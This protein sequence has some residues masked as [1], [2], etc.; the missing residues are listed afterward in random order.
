M[1]RTFDLAF[2]GG[3]IK[4]VAFVGALEAFDA[5]GHASRRLVGTSAGAIFAAA[6]AVGYTPAE[7]RRAILT[8]T[9]GR[10]PFADF[11]RV[12]A[13]PSG[14]AGGLWAAAGVTVDTLLGRV[15]PKAVGWGGRGLTFLTR[16]AVF[17]PTPFRT[18]MSQILLDKGVSPDEPLAELHERINRGRPQQLTL[19]AADVTAQEVL[20][21][22]ERTAPGL[23]ILEAVRMSMSIP[24]V[25]PEVE[26]RAEWGRYRGTDRAG[27]RVVDGGLLSNFPIRYLLDARYTAADGVLGPLAGDARP[28]GLFLD[29]DLPIP[30]L[31][32]PDREASILQQVPA[33]QSVLRVVDAMTDA[34]DREALRDLIPP[35]RERAIC[36]I[37]TKGV[38]PLDFGAD[39]ATLAG[40]IRSGR[41]AM[42]EW[43]AAHGGTTEL[44]DGMGR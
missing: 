19:I 33:V 4:G 43:S 41:D 40:L 37:G 18:W 7:M 22:N 31:A 38:G 14:L 6:R 24:F 28:L 17:D 12:P 21:L 23:P 15:W 26:W 9:D 2:K 27:H 32:L 25:W 44:A 30:G 8:R 3:G 39:D 16:G 20:V 36:R 10:L 5:A 13:R 42:K 35:G 34:Y 29:G 11:V 1:T